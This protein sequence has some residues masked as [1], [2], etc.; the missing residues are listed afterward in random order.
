MDEAGHFAK[1]AKTLSDIASQL[2]SIE[3]SG[4]LPPVVVIFMLNVRTI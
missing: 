2:S 4:V 1:I 3:R